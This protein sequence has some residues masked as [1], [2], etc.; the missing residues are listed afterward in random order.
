MT[1]KK[2]TSLPPPRADSEISTESNF[3]P[4]EESFT[5]RVYALRNIVP[6]TTRG[7][8]WQKVSH[9]LSAARSAAVT[10]GSALWIVSVSALIV[11]VP[12]AL[13]YAEDQQLA[14]MEEEQKQREKGGEMLTDGVDG[15]GPADAGAVLA[16][17]AL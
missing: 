13:M 5:E 3:D 7:W 9:G 14:A 10:T 17:P 11:V 15:L 6:A 2:L 4:S 16:K 1:N 12:W 8:A